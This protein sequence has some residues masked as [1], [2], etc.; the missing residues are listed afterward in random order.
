MT[1]YFRIT[2]TH[3]HT[4]CGEVSVNVTI[5]YPVL[6]EVRLLLKGKESWGQTN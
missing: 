1:A 4:Q 6:E 2:H 3:A 5:F